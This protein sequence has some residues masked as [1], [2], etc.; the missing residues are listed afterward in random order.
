MKKKTYGR[1]PLTLAEWLRRLSSL[2][3]S[4]S[5]FLALPSYI[6]SAPQLRP[7]PTCLRNLLTYDAHSEL[8]CGEILHI[9]LQR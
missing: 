6:Y 4:T 5:H 8:P 3:L 7:P 2:P 1:F 9:A